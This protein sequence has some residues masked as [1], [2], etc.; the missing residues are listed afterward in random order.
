MKKMKNDGLNLIK[1]CFLVKIIILLLRGQTK[2]FY[3]YYYFLILFFPNPHLLYNYYT[4]SLYHQ[5]ADQLSNQ[6]CGSEIYT[7]IFFLSWFLE[8]ALIVTFKTESNYFLLH[9]TIFSV[10]FFSSVLVTKKI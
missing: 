2:E 9:R 3:Y 5:F 6:L 1:Q 4:I 7:S 10:I 8:K